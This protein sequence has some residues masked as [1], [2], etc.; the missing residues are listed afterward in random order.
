MTSGHYWAARMPVLSSPRQ[1]GAQCCRRSYSWRQQTHSGSGREGHWPHQI[2]GQHDSQ[3]QGEVRE[4]WRRGGR[5]L[6]R[7]STHQRG[8]VHPWFLWAAS[9]DCRARAYG[10]GCGQVEEVWSVMVHII[11]P[12]NNIRIWIW[13]QSCEGLCAAYNVYTRVCV[14]KCY[15]QY[16]EYPHA[17][18]HCNTHLLYSY[19]KG[20]WRMNQKYLHFPKSIRQGPLNGLSKRFSCSIH[21]S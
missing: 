17:V 12:F 18:L 5:S 2:P 4:C 6:W 15:A 8:H 7:N 3:M 9:I 20:H 10:K 13:W 1:Q 19:S 21:C 16:C 14:W 11:K